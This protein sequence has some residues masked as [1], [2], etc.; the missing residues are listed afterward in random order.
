MKLPLVVAALV[1][2]T[3]SA[4]LAWGQNGH[5]IIGQI[6]QDNIDG[7]SRAAI[8]QII[9]DEDLATLSTF[10]D[11]ERSN[12]APFWQKEATPWH[13][14]TIPDG[15]SYADGGAPPEG[16]AYSALERFTVVLRDSAASQAEKRIALAFVVH[17]VGDLH[18]PMH[19][20]DG[21]DR[22]GNNV[23]VTFFGDRTNL[24]SVWDTSLIERQNLS[25]TEY[26]ARLER[27]MTPQNIIEWWT[28]DPL[29]WITE[30]IAVR[31]QAYPAIPADGGTSSL[32]YDYQ[33]QQ[34]PFVEQRLM[35]GGVRLAAYLD[36]VF[37]AEAQR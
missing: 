19:V 27:A 17:L 34:L 30:S 7:R 1:M 29:V 12:P 10:A 8:E 24:H 23:R 18:Q 16:N 2:S 9:G 15:E 20:G 36:H 11:E 3:P 31:K 32:S 35:Q 14:V 28:A 5:R 37:A 13:Y 21:T 33:Y 4:A 25:Y 6:A 22:G 26:T